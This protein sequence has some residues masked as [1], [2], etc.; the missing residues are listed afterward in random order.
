MK[1]NHI[2]RI[3]AVALLALAASCGEFLDT[4]PDNR[5]EIDTEAKLGKLVT[6]AYPRANIMVNFNAR[7]DNVS[8]KGYG[9]R[10]NLSNTDAFYWRDVNSTA[11]DSP[12]YFWSACYTA[13][14][15]ANQAVVSGEAMGTPGAQAYVAEARVARAFAHFMLVS[16]FARLYDPLTDNSSPGVPYITE[17]EDIVIKQYERGTVAGVYEKIEEDLLAGLKNLG[18]EGS[19]KAPRYH[20]GRAA[21]NA[22]ASRYYLFK[23]DFDKVVSHATEVIVQ[24]T[25]FV[26]PAEGLRN[27][28]MTDPAN[29][30][31]LN[32]F[33][34]WTG[35]YASFSSNEIKAYYAKAENKS[36]LLL[37]E[38]TSSLG[39]Y[40]NSWRY[41]CMKDDVNATVSAANPTGAKWAYKAYYSS[42]HWYV[43]KFRAIFSKSSINANSGSYYIVYPYLR[44]EEALLNRAEAFVHLDQPD[45]AIADLNIFARQRI[46]SYDEQANCL[47]LEKIH[48]FYKKQAAD[49]ENFMNKY[50]AYGTASWSEERKSLLL[51]V[52][53]CRRNEFMWEGLRY[54]DMWRYKIPIVHTTAENV[55]NTLWPGDDRWVLQIPEEASLSG[56]SQNPRANLLSPEW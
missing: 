56:V 6:S 22:F 46:K 54:W 50:G 1:Y 44:N 30:Y 34:P 7:V 24:P 36:N 8:D 53:D 21:A 20:F 33:Q 51:Y 15:H 10:E 12:S 52:L 5:T 43:P 35:D 26:E 13:I 38:M 49:P 3:P 39:N 23:G 2:I 17:P 47:T 29:V 32:N 28:D 48:A 19:Y 40:A 4:V 18:N 37:C 9:Y 42:I 45:K 27:V 55:T 16:T 25:K 11:Q 41:A 31:A 14:A